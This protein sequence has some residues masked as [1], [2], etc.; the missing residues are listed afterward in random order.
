MAQPVSNS[1]CKTIVAYIDKN[2]DNTGSLS[3]L[4]HVE[5]LKKVSKGNASPKHNPHFSPSR[6]SFGLWMK[7]LEENGGAA[8]Q[9]KQEVK[10]MN[11]LLQSLSQKSG[12]I[13]IKSILISCNTV[14]LTLTERLGFDISSGFLNSKM[15]QRGCQAEKVQAAEK[16]PRNQLS[17]GKRTA[18]RKQNA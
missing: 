4:L 12:S 17:K 1:P 14:Y 16:K 2:E 3:S 7:D 9:M 13:Q 8:K 18:L 10:Q 5:H 6:Y 11:K 15:V